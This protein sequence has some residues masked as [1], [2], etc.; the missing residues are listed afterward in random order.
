MRAVCV[1]T[2]SGATQNTTCLIP[3][4]PTG[5]HQHH[6]HTPQIPLP[7]VQAANSSHAA[8]GQRHCKLAEQGTQMTGFSSVCENSVYV[9]ARAR[10]STNA[11]LYVSMTLGSK[12]TS[13]AQHKHERAVFWVRADDINCMKAQ[14]TMSSTQDKDCN[15]EDQHLSLA[16]PAACALALCRKSTAHP[17]LSHKWE[18]EWYRSRGCIC[19]LNK[20]TKQSEATLSHDN[21]SWICSG[22][23][24]S[25][26]HW[27]SPA[28]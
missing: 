1:S 4:T 26:I 13:T 9:C 5:V 27:A 16:P 12:T 2:H 23:L 28:D 21:G 3:S 20:Y 22:L 18:L 14:P 19:I 6:P 17:L 8:A 15:P 10:V 25:Q 24:T 11:K 7:C